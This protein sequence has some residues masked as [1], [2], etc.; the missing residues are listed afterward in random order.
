M[1]KYRRYS[2]PQYGSAS[3]ASGRYP[4]SHNF[5]LSGWNTSTQAGQGYKTLGRGGA[6]LDNLY[7]AAPG[8]SV[9]EEARLPEDAYKAPTYDAGRESLHRRPLRYQCKMDENYR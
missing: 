3:K 8:F 5:P 6:S 7:S 9:S 4:S 1:K 2:K